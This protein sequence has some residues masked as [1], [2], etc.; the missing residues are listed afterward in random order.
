MNKPAISSRA[1][2][3][4]PS[5]SLLFAASGIINPKLLSPYA[6]P[7]FSAAPAKAVD[8]PV[9]VLVPSGATLCD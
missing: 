3:K 2:S 6:R 9:S 7:P 8:S 5:L 4:F 1:I